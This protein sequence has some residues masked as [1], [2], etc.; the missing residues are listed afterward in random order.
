MNILC[1]LLVTKR[2]VHLTAI[3]YHLPFHKEIP[4]ILNNFIAFE[5]LG[6]PQS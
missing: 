3:K 6:E 5:L 2:F 1:I 4:K